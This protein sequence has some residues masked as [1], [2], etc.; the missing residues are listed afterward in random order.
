MTQGCSPRS[1]RLA[2]RASALVAA[3]ALGACAAQAP[4]A[5]ALVLERPA[6]TAPVTDALVAR[7][8]AERDPGPGAPRVAARAHALGPTLRPLFLRA[9]DLVEAELGTDLSD[10]G[11]HVVDDDSILAE[12][13]VET[14]RLV[15]GQLGDGPLAERLLESLV[16]GQIG[17]Y[18]ALY[19]GRL[20]SVMV[21]RDVLQGY[22]AS[23]PDT[24]A[25]REEA[26][27]VLMLHELVHAA[28]D[29]RHGIHDNRSLDFRA[30]FAQ[31]AA[32]EGHAQWRTRTIC[33]REGCLGGLDALD[34][35]MF[36]DGGAARRGAETA[37]H[38]AGPGRPGRATRR[39]APLDRNLLEYSYVEG[40]RFVA[41]LAARPDGAALLERLLVDP[42]HDPLQ[43][44]DPDSFPDTSR[45]ARNRDLLAVARN[46]E[47]PWLVGPD[48]RVSVA[49]SPLKGVDLRDDPERRAA[50]IDGFTRLVTAMVAVQ[51]HDPGERARPPIE[52]TLMRTD[53][54]ETARLFA[55]TLH[56]HARLPGA[57]VLEP[58][59]AERDGAGTG[60]TRSTLLRTELPTRGGDAWRT[61]VATDGRFVV[62]AS[63]RTGSSAPIDAYVIGVLDALVAGE[64]T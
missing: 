53:R 64:P 33:R 6:A 43:I 19:S 9:R 27:L 44:L 47:H 56:A 17:T 31:S 26:L 14:R 42:P 28:D 21:S 58:P 15:S 52:V 3:S 60:G 1:R 45:E 61:V 55:D 38:D 24:R 62:Q 8:E 2:R 54:S 50:A 12:V 7:A 4:P 59:D 48:A 36:D 40:E 16:H 46:V 5:P 57:K 13:L 10:I 34:A 51:F 63:G 37:R 30:S 20:R 39:S 49:T 22:L 18:A 23:L 35:F 25:A 32:F 11:L 29:L 41:A